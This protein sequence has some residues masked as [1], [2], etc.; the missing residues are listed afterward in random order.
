M[1]NRKIDSVELAA[2]EAITSAIAAL[3]DHEPDSA[4]YEQIVDQITKL[5]AVTPEI[6]VRKPLSLDAIFTVFGSL[7]GIG[8]IIRHEELNVITSK[9]LS[10]VKKV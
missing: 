8:M 4:E 9:A 6:P 10:F 3:K 5:K 2:N 7:A 1:F